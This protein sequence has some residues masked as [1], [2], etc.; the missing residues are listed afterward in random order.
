MDVVILGAG[1]H[2]S[3]LFHICQDAGII[4]RKYLDD[5]VDHLDACA[6][7]AA[8]P[9]DVGYLIGINSPDKRCE[10][11]YTHH[12]AAIA[13]HPTAHIGADF[14]ASPGV[15]VAAGCTI[16]H[17]VTLGRHVHVNQASSLIRCTVGDYTTIAP[18]VHIAG[19]VTIGSGVFVGIGARISNLVAIGDGATI[20]AG[21][22][23]VDDVPPLS[24][25]VGVPA[26]PLISGCGP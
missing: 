13:I 24:T 21:A 16:G 8:Q 23:V 12:E 1:S 9:A 6:R 15:V 10:F 3:D 2:G 20:G 17:G 19:D 26:R 18:G 11:D 4:V 14:H 25:Y 5:N 22:V 7:L